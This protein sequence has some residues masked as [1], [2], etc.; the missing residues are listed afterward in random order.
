MAHSRLWIA[1][2]AVL[3]LATPAWAEP[4]PRAD[5]RAL[6]AKIDQLIAARW[7]TEHVTPAPPADD[8]AFLRR[9]SLDVIGRIPVVAETRPFLRDPTS[10]KR[11]QAIDRLLDS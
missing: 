5:A 7:Q 2:L 3:G 1:A 4:D 8:G 11:E 6:A 10:A 9:L